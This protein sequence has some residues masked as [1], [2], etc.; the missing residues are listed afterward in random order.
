MIS[1]HRFFIPDDTV[2]IKACPNQ[3]AVWI[4]PSTA[5]VQS[6]KTLQINNHSKF[7]LKLNSPEYYSYLVLAQTSLVLQVQDLKENQKLIK[8]WIP[9]SNGSI[10]A[11]K[12][13]QQKRQEGNIQVERQA[14]VAKRAQEALPP[15]PPVPTRKSQAEQRKKQAQKQAILEE[16]QRLLQ[17][18]RNAL[19][20][21]RKQLELQAQRQK[22]E[23]NNKKTNEKKSQEIEQQKQVQMKQKQ[24][25]LKEQKQKQILEQIKNQLNEKAKLSKAEIKPQVAILQSQVAI[26][27]VG[28]SFQKPEIKDLVK[29]PTV[30]TKYLDNVQS[31]DAYAII[32]GI[33]YLEPSGES[34]SK[35]IKLPT[36]L[37]L[38]NFINENH[39]IS[40][41]ALNNSVFQCLFVNSSNQAISFSLPEDK[42]LKYIDETREGFTKPIIP[43]GTSRVI[44]FMRN[45]FFNKETGLETFYYVF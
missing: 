34:E 37:D 16:K 19:E 8:K 5:N 31:L 36:A 21:E 20:N 44:Y 23:V 41:T 26:Q 1:E 2:V 12:N 17:E 22:T 9:L 30:Y 10:G 27:Q 35:T 45:G 11:I 25:L 40:K 4:L 42:S 7:Q 38:D 29:Y 33:I 3:N 43:S 24:E 39:N 18:Q 32:G 6:S 14:I 15:P 28:S 13:Q